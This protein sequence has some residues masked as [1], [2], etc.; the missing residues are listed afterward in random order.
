MKINNVHERTINTTEEEAGRLLDSLSGK[1]DR[2]W[3]GDRWPPMRFNRPLGVGA[4]GGH[5]PIRYSVTEYDPGKRI[6]FEFNGASGPGLI[7]N[8]FFEVLNNGRGVSI[9]HTIDASC[10]GS[11]LIKWPLIIRPFHDALLED[12]LD[13]AQDILGDPPAMRAKYSSWVRFLKS[14]FARL[15]KKSRKA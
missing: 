12:A 15:A 14:I 9:R 11:M 5:G 1:D 7:G 8:H 4:K 13:N 2:F 10:K 6:V 3:P